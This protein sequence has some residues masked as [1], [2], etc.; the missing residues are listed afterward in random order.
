[1]TVRGP[2][3]AHPGAEI[4]AGSQ[5]FDITVQSASWIEASELEVVVR[6]ETVDTIPLV[7]TGTASAHVYVATVPLSLTSGDWVLFHARGV[8]DLSPL[9]PGREPFAVSNPMFVP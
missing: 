9:H 2:G 7:D 4:A 6:G 5:S 3:D 8:G 1:M